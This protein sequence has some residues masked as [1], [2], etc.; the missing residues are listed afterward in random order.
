MIELPADVLEALEKVA[1]ANGD[2]IALFKAL[3]VGGSSSGSIIVPP[4]NMV[5]ILVN[6]MLH[7]IAHLVDAQIR[8]TQLDGQLAILKTEMEDK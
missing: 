3:S 4:A 2:F 5:P 1:T 7:V 6:L 8:I